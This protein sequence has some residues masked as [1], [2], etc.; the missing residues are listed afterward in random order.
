VLEH[1]VPVQVDAERVRLSFPEGSFFGRQAGSE[2][3]R[4]ALAEAAR[5]VLG[6]PP[7]I[8]IAFGV[9][10]ARPTVAAQQAARQKERRAEIVEVALSHP[11]VKEAMDVF[12]EAEGNVDV[13]VEV[14]G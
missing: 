12:P 13:Q 10:S 1:G 6:K 7:R 8:E 4:E 11:R 3:A 9:E 2:P 5:G 14:E